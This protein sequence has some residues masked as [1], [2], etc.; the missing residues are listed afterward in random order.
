M[1]PMTMFNGVVLA[2]S[3]AISLGLSVV[4]LI[5][6]LLRPSH[7]ELGGNFA[8]L[9]QSAGAFAAVTLVAAA[10]FYAQLRHKAWRWWAQ[11]GLV[12]VLVA[13][14]ALSL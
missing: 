11:L 1:R 5:S 13:A 8:V 2:S 10:A 4:W 9:T 7:P 14:L 12:L 6:L 3:F